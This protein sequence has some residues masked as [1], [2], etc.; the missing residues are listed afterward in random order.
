ME[1]V[2]TLMETA[3]YHIFPAVPPH[4]TYNIMQNIQHHVTC[5]GQQDSE[6][7]VLH[8][9]AEPVHTCTWLKVK[10]TDQ[11]DELL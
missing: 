4:R 5:E 11:L 6:V 10:R 7:C 9:I 8:F 3:V 2:S 1:I